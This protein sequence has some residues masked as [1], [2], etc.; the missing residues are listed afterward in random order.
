MEEI[1]QEEAMKGLIFY[2]QIFVENVGISATKE[3]VTKVL[4]QIT[5]NKPL[6]KDSCRQSD[7]AG[8]RGI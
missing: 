5:D 1:T 6:S 8:L 3:V 2:L 7:V 4:N